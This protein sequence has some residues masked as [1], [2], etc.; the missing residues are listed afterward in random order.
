MTVVAVVVSLGLL[1]A[2]LVGFFTD[3]LDLPNE[4][5]AVLDQR[6]SVISMF[7][8]LAGL[9]IAGT[10]LVLQLRSSSS[11]GEAPPAETGGE[12]HVDLS[13]GTFHGPVTGM[14]TT[15][16]KADGTSAATIGRDNS[17]VIVTGANSSIT[18][19]TSSAGAATAGLAL[20]PVAQ[21]PVNG[22]IGLPR[23]ASAV[24][25]GREDHLRTLA[26]V[27]GQG[28]GVIAQAVVGLGGI[29]KSELALHHATSRR[30]DYDLIWWIDA[31][32]AD[33][34]QAGLA[35]LCRALC[36]S[37]SSAAAAHA[38]VCE[39]EAWALAW[40][41][42]H[43][44]WLLVFDNADDPA[45]VQ[46]YL[47]RLHT[48][49]VLI[50]SRRSTDWSDVGTVVRLGVLEQTAAV[51]LLRELIGEATAWDQALA[52]E[53]AAE[54]D[55]LPLALRHAGAYIATVPGMNLARYLR[56]L[57]TTPA[58]D[59]GRPGLLEEVV[60]RSLAITTD[61]ISQ[62]DPLAINIL[63]LLACYAPELLP[64]QVLYGMCDTGNAGETEVAEALRVLASYSV[65]G[66]SAD[67]TAV[68]VHRLVQAATLA[69]LTTDEHESTQ[70]HAAALLQAAL[71]DDAKALAN[72][73]VYTELLPHARAA[74]AP[75]S[76]AMGKVIIYLDAVGDWRTAHALQHQRLTAISDQLGLE[77]PH[78]LTARHNLASWTG[79]TGD[80]VGAREMLTQLLPVVERVLGAEHPDTLTTRHNLARW[81]GRAGD[82]MAAR[83]M[84]AQ[85]L[86]A[87]ERVLGAE[88][89]DTLATRHNLASWTGRAGDAVKARE[90]FAQLLPVR[91]RVLG[92]EHPDTLTNRNNLASWTGRAGDAVKAREMLTQLLPVRERV[93][94]VEH[95][96]TLAT[97]HNL[98]RWTGQAGDTAKA[99]EMLTQLLPVRERVLGAKHSDTLT[100]RN[101]LASWTGQAGDVVGAREMLA[102]LLPVAERALG[103]K[104]PGTLATRHNLARWT[105]EIGNVIEARE[106][107]AQL[108][109]MRERVL[110]AEHPSTLATRH[111]LAHWTGEAGDAVEAREMLMQL[112]PVRERVQG[113]EHPNTLRTRS[114]LAN[115]IKKAP[116]EP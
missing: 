87:R 113:A 69:T 98:A 35:G 11:M 30:H 3:P 83:E 67:G 5:L 36:A 81:T 78:T 80:A 86:P 10:A 92:A 19:N 71:P 46:P 32:G 37:V 31:D 90:M 96:S 109:P 68:S 13:G 59:T 60:G 91:E 27:L 28:P 104:H 40:L 57:R 88:H 82:V 93:L 84:L 25:V 15:Q 77:H 1:G 49:H 17:G 47:G 100:N 7:T 99:R 65:I 39:A 6:A 4:V 9:L 53:L 75:G 114:D 41:S 116:Q 42:A 105:G 102:Q 8:G 112:L 43:R 18:L 56:L 79:R 62:T 85:L 14:T 66:R 23:R 26:Q 64:C 52:E 54:L 73:A 111:E 94:G 33:A 103:G 21:V 44:R 115:W 55:G 97:R 34:A 61:R 101:D 76:V 89:P 51:T 95:P 16:V 63:R 38:T 2:G 110:G 22:L 74:L 29:G 108:L 106:M 50:T 48:G 107:L 45:H 20:P 70:R 58:P 72:R 24:F 12:N